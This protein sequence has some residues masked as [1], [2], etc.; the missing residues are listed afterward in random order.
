MALPGTTLHDNSIHFKL[1]DCPDYY[2]SVAN[3][4]RRCVA[5]VPELVNLSPEPFLDH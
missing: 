5:D 2:D 3:I 1:D 4:T